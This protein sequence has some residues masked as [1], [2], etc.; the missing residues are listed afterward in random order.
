MSA[1]SHKAM[2]MARNYPHIGF[3][4]HADDAICHCQS[5]KEARALWSA[6]AD[7]L[8]GCKLVLHPGKTKI[9]YCKDADLRD[10]AYAVSFS[11]RN[12]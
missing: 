9:V 7:R 12:P 10:G 8:A 3:E 1:A 5:A 6:L 11:R 4:R 2:W